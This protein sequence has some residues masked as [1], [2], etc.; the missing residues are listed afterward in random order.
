MVTFFNQIISMSL[1]SC[2]VILVVF[3]SRL[4]VK[5]TSYRMACLLW[6]IVAIRLVFPYAPESKVS[7]IPD[8]VML[9]ESTLESHSELYPQQSYEE[10]NS[11]ANEVNLTYESSVEN[12]S[13]TSF[14]PEETK[15]TVNPNEFAKPIVNIANK[16]IYYFHCLI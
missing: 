6:I 8:R 15:S 13:Y 3:L 10:S 16:D 2:V 9:I 4:V 14:E 11:N 12:A 7:I 5:K 1:T